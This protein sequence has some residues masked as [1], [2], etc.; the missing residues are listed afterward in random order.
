MQ[1]DNRGF[2][3]AMP[4][5][6]SPA[7]RLV[8]PSL[9]NTDQFAAG[10]DEYAAVGDGGGADSIA[11]DLGEQIPG[12]ELLGE[13]GRGGMGVVFKTKQISLNRI[14]ALKM[15]LRGELASAGDVA[16]FRAEAEAA[17]RLNHPHIVSVYEVGEQNGQ[18]YFSMKYVEGTTLAWS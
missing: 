10:A 13:L 4:K 12:Y 18:P 8:Q 3:K 6:L 5:D 1:R 11:V 15:I 2:S 17:A 7:V 9:G 16:R 14:V